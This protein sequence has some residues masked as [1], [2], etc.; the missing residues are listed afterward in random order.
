[1][2]ESSL[3]GW[4]VLAFPDSPLPTPAESVTPAESSTRGRKRRHNATERR[5]V[6]RLNGQ[7]EELRTEL[8]LPP[9]VTKSDVLA[10]ALGQ[11]RALRAT[12]HQRFSADP[13]V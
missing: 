3:D 8:D 12:Q 9:S 7:Y 4:G 6:Q 5:R 10:A 2:D 1:M 13:G 11:L